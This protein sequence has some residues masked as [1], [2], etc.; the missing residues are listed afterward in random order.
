LTDSDKVTL[1]G[2]LAAFFRLR[3]LDWFN[4]QDGVIDEKAWTAYRNAIKNMMHYPSLRKWWINGGY[5]VFDP[6]FVRHVNEFIADVPLATENPISAIFDD[7][8]A[9]FSPEIGEHR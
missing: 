2:F 4:Y 8:Y 6:A 5:G 1:S 3:E 7:S 9:P